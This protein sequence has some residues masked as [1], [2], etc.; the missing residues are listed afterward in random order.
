MPEGD[1]TLMSTD[2][3]RRR[4]RLDWLLHETFEASILL[5]GAFALLEVAGG[6]LLWLVGANAFLELVSWLTQAEVAEDPKDWIATSLLHWAQGFSLATQHFYALY[7]FSHGAVKLVLVAGLLRGARWA[8]PAAL[9][10]MTA[11]VAYQL[12]RFS[13]TRSFGLIWLSIF[14]VFLITL[15]AREWRR[16]AAAGSEAPS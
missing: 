3:A 6:V 10:V 9:A 1:E 5:K 8:Y 15:I 12:Y 11:F 4:S 16:T 13:Y 2:T 7:L 14:D